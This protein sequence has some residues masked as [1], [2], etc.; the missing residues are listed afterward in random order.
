M[1][2]KLATLLLVAVTALL[3]LA[4]ALPI[5]QVL[6]CC[7]QVAKKVDKRMLRNMQSFEIQ[8]DHVCAIKAV[9]VKVPQRTFCLDPNIKQLKKWMKR[10]QHKKVH[11]RR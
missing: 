5:T 2:L 9:L 11:A 1:G 7:T 10:N 8:H 4:A 3:H 6:N